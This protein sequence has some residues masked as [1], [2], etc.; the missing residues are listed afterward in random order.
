MVALDWWNG[1]RSILSN[2][3][4]TGTIVGLRLTTKPE[5]IYRALLEATAYGARVILEAFAAG[6]VTLEELYAAGG[7]PAKNPLMMQIYADVLGRE[8]RVP[9]AAPSPALGSAIYTAVAAGCYESLGLAAAAMA[10]AEMLVYRPIADNAEKYE[11]L[12]AVYGEL[13]DWLGVANRHLMAKLKE[14]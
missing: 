14:I 12:F 10:P 8:I 6:G 2:A 5:E 13:H 9:K 7:I 1:N 11:K 3:D 4:L